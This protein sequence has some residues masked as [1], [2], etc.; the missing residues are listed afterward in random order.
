[1]KK[2][3]FLAAALCLC[4]GS[5]FAQNP[6]Y[7]PGQ[8]IK[9]GRTTD[10]YRVCGNTSSADGPTIEFVGNS[11]SDQPGALNLLAGSTTYWRAINF[12]KETGTTSSPGWK[13]L[14]TLTR[15]G[16]FGIGA[17]NSSWELRASFQ[18][19][20]T[21]NRVTM[22]TMGLNT[23][24]D[25]TTI[26]RT[27]AAYSGGIGYI[28]FNTARQSDNGFH[29]LTDGTKNGG[30]LIFGTIDGGLNFVT[31][32]SG[33]YSGGASESWASTAQVAAAIRMS[34]NPNGKVFIGDPASV[35][36]YATLNDFG[37]YVKGGGV[38]AERFKCDLSTS[39]WADYVFESSYK[40]RPLSEVEQFIKENKHLPEVPSAKKVE[41]EGID[42]AEMDAILLKKIEELTLYMIELKKENTEM[43]KELEL[44]KK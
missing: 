43:K 40:L 37:L 11:N 21:Y 42:V 15:E 1:M 34:I 13:G 18:L 26:D 4:S 44:L 32:K 38:R 20:K 22:G 7:T 30:S 27:V 19:D 8:D 33:A 16:G 39:G 28:G 36:N 12:T 14:A 6:T 31:F 35:S 25:G 29:L 24:S 2:I 5:L 10:A 3:K 41:S 9:A 17:F 23:L